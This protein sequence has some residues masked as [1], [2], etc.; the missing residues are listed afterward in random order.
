MP[1]GRLP[2]AG[3]LHDSSMAMP[4]YGKDQAAEFTLMNSL[5]TSQTAPHMSLLLVQNSHSTCV[6]EL[7]RPQH[8]FLSPTGD[9]HK[10]L[11][12]ACIL[13]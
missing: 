7:M 2:D 6:H 11:T 5:C 4:K 13:A 1:C 12:E 9:N 8:P 10:A 3:Q